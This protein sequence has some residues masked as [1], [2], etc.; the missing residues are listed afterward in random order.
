MRALKWLR[1][2][3]KS[4][5]GNVLV[6]GAA[7]MPLLIGSAA[8][9]VDTIQLSLWKR[10]LQRAA[11][12]ASIAGAHSVTQQKNVTASVQSDLTLN[13]DIPLSLTPVIENAPTVG[14]FAGDNRAVRVVL[15][16]QRP[17]PFL[18]FFMEQA[19]LIRVEAT[20][21]VVHRGEYCMVSLEDGTTAGIEFQGNT[22]IDLGCGMATNSRAN[23]AV[24]ANGSSKIKATPVAAMGGLTP[25]T[26][27]IQPTTLQPYSIKQEDPFATLANPTI[28]NGSCP[29]KDIQPQDTV[30]LKPGCFKSLNIKGTV[31]MDPGVYY[32]DGGELGFGSQAHVTGEGVTFVLTSKTAAT[33]GNTVATLNMSAGAY[34]NLTAPESGTYEGILFYQDRRATLGGGTNKVNGNADSVLE[35]A[36]YFPRQDLTMNGTA[37][38]DTRCLQMVARRLFFSGNSRIENECP[39]NGAHAFEATVVRLVG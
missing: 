38:M 28:P 8:L 2:L 1:Q 7:S 4:E 18:S 35:G 37:G 20:A 13:N 26:N 6:I 25:S 11:D 19:P 23:A 27:F 5:K 22:D 30:N 16:A 32:I 36:F 9:A 21:A 12:S 33:N 31:T 29:N 34:V 17:L 10:Q 3:R 39:E 15:T 14:D 24:T